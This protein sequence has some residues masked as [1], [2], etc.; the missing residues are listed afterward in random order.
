MYLQDLHRSRIMT[1]SVLWMHQLNIVQARIRHPL[2]FSHLFIDKDDP[3]LSWGAEWP[4]SLS[5]ATS[6]GHPYLVVGV[7]ILIPNLAKQT[8]FSSK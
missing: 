7:G 5:G 6:A 2:I 3:I 1:I 8:R 4:S